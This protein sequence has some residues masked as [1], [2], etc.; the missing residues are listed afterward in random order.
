MIARQPREKLNSLEPTLTLGRLLCKVL[1]Q[2][3]LQTCSVFPW[4]EVIACISFTVG[5][6]NRDAAVELA[7]ALRRMYLPG[8]VGELRQGRNSIGQQEPTFRCPSRGGWDCSGRVRCCWA[9]GCCFAGS[10]CRFVLGTGALGRRSRCLELLGRGEPVDQV[11]ASPW[12]TC[13]GCR[14]RWWCLQTG[15][16]LQTQE[17]QESAVGRRRSGER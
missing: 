15:Y 2:C 11:I 3:S 5:K 12:R 9:D 16:G 7:Q 10:T 4:Y 17:A 14:W 1:G 13:E 8:S 6:I